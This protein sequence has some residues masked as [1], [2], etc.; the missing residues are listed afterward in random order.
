MLI[1]TD[2]LGQEIRRVQLGGPRHD[3]GRRLLPGPD[4]G[5][6]VLGSTQNESHGSFDMYLLYLNADLEVVWEKRYGGMNWEYGEDMVR[7]ENGNFVLLGSQGRN[8]GRSQG[9]VLYLDAKGKLLSETSLTDLI[10]HELT[11]LTLLPN[12]S[13]LVAGRSRDDLFS[14]A[15]VHHLNLQGLPIAPCPSP[16]ISPN[17]QSPAPFSYTSELFV[18]GTAGTGQPLFQNTDFSPSELPPGEYHFNVWL[19]QLWKLGG[20]YR[21]Y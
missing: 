9:L 17:L 21:V 5:W 10:S 18:P 8:S 4:Q 12:G 20:M 7:L 11:G 2:T 3:F 13:L 14:N 15:W 19:N 1:E 16:S 6:Y